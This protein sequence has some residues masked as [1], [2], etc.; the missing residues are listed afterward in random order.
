MIEIP[1]ELGERR[2]P[3]VIGHGLAR[4][5]GERARSADE[6]ARSLVVSSPRVWTLHGAR[7]PAA[8][9]ACRSAGPRA[10]RRRRASQD[11]EDPRSA[12]RR[13]PGGEASAATGVVVAV[14][15]GVVGDVAGFAAATYMRGVAWVGVPTTLLS[16]VDSS[17]GGKVGVNHPKAKNLLGAFHQPRAVVVDPAFLETLARPR[18]AERRLRG[19]EVRRPRRSGALPRAPEARPPTCAS[20]R[21]PSS[22]TRSRRRA[23]SRPWWWRRTSARGACGKILNLGHTLGHALE[24]VTRYRRFTHGEAVGWGLVGAAAIARRKGLL[25]DAGL[26]GHREGRGPPG[27]TAQDVGPLRWPPSWRRSRRDKKAEAGRVPFILPTAIGR[28]TIAADVAVADIRHALR[29]MAIPGGAAG[30]TARREAKLGG[31]AISSIMTAFCT[32]RRFSAWSKITD[33]GPSATSAAT[34][35]PRC[36]GRQ[37]M[38][39]ASGAATAIRSSVT[40]NPWK[41]L[42]RASDSASWPMDVHTS[43]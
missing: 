2:Y 23:A 22:R 24:T 18:G 30:P 13:V 14:G 21:A 17:I 32:W 28:V 40:A 36:A 8:C 35:S 12:P 34:S 11:A 1:V 16:M 5:L 39:T 42:R 20:G 19:P 27:P 26:R 37:C 6:A 41:A 31:I 7:S 29:V 25:K 4:L 15:G 10:L 43:V 9:G 38:K 33:C 3:I